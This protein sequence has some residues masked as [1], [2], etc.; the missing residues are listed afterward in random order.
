[1]RI[2]IVGSGVVGRATGTVFHMC[3]NEVYFYDVDRNRLKTLQKE[4][5]NVVDSL[6]C[7]VKKSDV[8][9]VCVP[10][11]TVDGKFAFDYVNDAVTGIGRALSLLDGY[12]VVVVRSTVLPTTTRCKVVPI[13]ER[14]SGLRAG[15]GFGV[16]MNP[17]FLREKN[18]FED[19]LNPARI[20]VGE[21]D[22]QSG[23]VLEKLYAPFNVPIIRTTLDTAEVIKYAANLF[24]ATKISFFNEM[25]MIGK[26]IGAD[27]NLVSKA[28]SM[29]PRIGEYGVLGGN[30]FD[31]KCLPKD[32]EAFRN[33]AK[34]T[35]LNP[36][37][38][39]A[40]AL[41]NEQISAYA[42]R[43]GK[44]KRTPKT[45]SGKRK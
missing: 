40:V 6:F 34:S 42:S 37:L 39:D 41:V 3:G 31:G 2:A 24:L 44:K 10:T 5:Y 15:K 13:L 35:R 20:V 25:Y 17:E 7:A 9:F 23:D 36:K 8:V 43:N 12:R 26:E 38:L 16:C 45:R 21:L 1:M 32:L 11:P 22:G 19:S 27:M 33:Y 30:P 18:A 28:V 14:C 29:D 4:G